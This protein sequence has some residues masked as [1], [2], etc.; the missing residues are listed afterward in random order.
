MYIYICIYIYIYTYRERK[1]VFMYTYTYTQYSSVK[2]VSIFVLPL[3]F[4]FS[5][6]VNFQLL[7]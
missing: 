5:L 3:F 1:R 2:F 4:V 6:G 7:Y